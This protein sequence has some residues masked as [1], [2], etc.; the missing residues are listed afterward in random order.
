[1]VSSCHHQSP[2]HQPTLYSLALR[3]ALVSSGVSPRMV[4][5]GKDDCQDMWLCVCV[6]VV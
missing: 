1:M 2:T 3:P 4:E 5:G 6:C